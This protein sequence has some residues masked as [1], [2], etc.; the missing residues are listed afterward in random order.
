M[1]YSYKEMKP[2]VLKGENQ[3]S[4]LN[5]RDRVNALFSA[6]AERPIAVDNILNV[7][8]GSEGDATASADWFRMACLDR[9]VELG[10][11]F[12]IKTHPDTIGQHRVFMKRT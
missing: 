4:F 8:L 12:E 10:E 9:M 3:K 11:L 1:P 5:V 7:D 6:D 2:V